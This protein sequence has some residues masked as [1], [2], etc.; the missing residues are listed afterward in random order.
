MINTKYIVCRFQ[1]LKLNPRECLRFTNCYGKANKETYA[2][3]ERH[4]IG[5][6]LFDSEPIGNFLSARSNI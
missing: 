2:L 5:Y 6:R 4:M 1:A 3:A